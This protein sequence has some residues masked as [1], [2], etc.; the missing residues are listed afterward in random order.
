MP[1][2]DVR[3][4]RLPNIWMRMLRVRPSVTAPRSKFVRENPI[5]REHDPC[6][7]AFRVPLNVNKIQ[8]R[9]YLEEI[10]K[11]DVVKV[12]TMIYLGKER[13]SHRTGLRQ[14]KSDYKKAYVTIKQPFKYPSLEEQRNM[15]KPTGTE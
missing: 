7:V 13:R 15:G 5:P 2:F 12:N 11:I 3:Q 6:L 4:F 14:K 1:P 10:Y 8:I 9:N